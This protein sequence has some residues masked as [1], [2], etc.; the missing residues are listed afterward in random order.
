M[1]FSVWLPRPPWGAQPASG[2]LEGHGWTETHQEL[3]VL[4]L[5][6]RQWLKG[7]WLIPQAPGGQMG[8]GASPYG[9][10]IRKD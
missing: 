10:C 6:K 7:F 1:V 2:N 9:A 5:K 8:T 3:E 4:T